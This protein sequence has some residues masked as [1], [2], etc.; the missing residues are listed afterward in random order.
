MS[1]MKYPYRDLGV[2]FDRNFRNDLNANFDDIEHDIR[3]IGGE[4]AQQALE[5]AEE[6]NTQAIYAQ[7]SGDYAQDK[8]DYAA[9]QGD[10]AQTQGNFAN[11]KGL[12]AQQQGDYA[13]AQGD[14]AKQVGDENKTR[15]LNPVATFADIATTYPNP[16]H[17][18]TVMVTDDG[19]NSGSVYR[20]ENGQWNLTQK[21]ND[22]AIADVQNKIGISSKKIEGFLAVKEYENL[23]VAIAQGYDWQPAIQQAINDAIIQ[24]KVPL[25]PPEVLLIANSIRIPNKGKLYGF[26]KLISILK[27]T[28]NFPAVIIDGNATDGVYNWEVSGIALDGNDIGSIGIQINYARE[29]TIKNCYISGFQKGVTAEQSWTNSIINSDIVDNSDK[30]VELGTQSNNFNLINTRLDRA[31]NYGLHITAD[32]QTINLEGCVIQ[33][34]GKDGILADAGRSINIKGCYFENNNTSLTAGCGEI[35]LTGSAVQVQGVFIAGTQIWT[36]NTT[37]GIITDRVNGLSIHGGAISKVSGGTSVYSIQTSANTI[38]VFISGMYKD[39]PFNDVGKCIFSLETPVFKYN[40]GV[41][42]NNPIWYV[43]TLDSTTPAEYHQYIAGVLRTVFKTDS[44]GD[45]Y[46]RHAKTDGTI[47]DIF[48]VNGNNRVT[49]Y[50]II[51]F[52]KIVSANRVLESGTT[53]NRPASPVLGQEYFDTTIKKPIWFNGTNWQDAAGN[54]V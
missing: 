50:Q 22:L 24:N 40:G 11:E 49:M 37:A 20:Y 26:G 21:H 41:R 17:G 52:N 2:P 46:F 47:Q 15:W 27:P 34:C 9:Q 13:K 45:F 54:I 19:E 28:G 38:N 10:Y 42:K 1:S 43:D 32:S 23:K 30:N 25:L 36:K 44:A 53:A 5:A 35:N 12:Y 3:M 4:A 33:S 29:G 14:Y 8:G 31:G 48:R 6:A 51:D 16:Q 39:N 7:T 18:D